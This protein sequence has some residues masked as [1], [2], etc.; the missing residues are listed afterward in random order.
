MSI[1][2]LTPNNRQ[3]AELSLWS[4]DLAHLADEIERADEYADLYH[5]DVADGHFSPQ[6]VF[7]PELVARL[8]PLTKKLF[9]V[10]MMAMNSILLDQVDQFIDAGA[11]IITIWYENGDLVPEALDKISKANVSA[12]LSI[13]LDVSPEV[14]IPYFDR[15]ELITLIGTQI[16]IKGQNLSEEA[17]PRIRTMRKLLK[18]YGYEDKIKISAD[19]GIRPHTVP[20][21]ID[22]GADIVVMG[23]MAYGSQDIKQTFE[24]LR[25]LSRPL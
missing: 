14:I 24:W 15:I 21:L 23:S 5:I 11:D 18:E 17:C 10:H 8:R 2:E 16:G 13:G 9:H 4:A 6:F 22:A 20:K 3:L 1:W 7:F 12:G 25:S 19:G